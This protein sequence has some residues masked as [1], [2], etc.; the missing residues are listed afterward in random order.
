MQEIDKLYDDFSQMPQ[1]NWAKLAKQ[2]LYWHK[3]FTETLV[4]KSYPE[5]TWFADG[6]TNISYNCLDT[7]LK[8]HSNKTALH[9]INSQQK[10]TKLSYQELHTEVIKFANY[11]KKLGINKGDFITFYMPLSCEAVIAMLA[12]VRIGAIHSIVFAGFSAEALA[13][14]IN[15]TK[16][17]WLI[18][19]DIGYRKGKELPLLE[20]CLKAHES[21][22]IENIV[23]YNRSGKFTKPQN[24]EINFYEMQ[25]YKKESSDSDPISWQDAE[26]PSFVLYTSG[27][28]GKPKGLVHSTGGYLLWAKLSTRL[29]F[30]LKETDTYWCTAD[31]GWITGHTYLVYGPLANAATIFFYEDAPDFPNTNI[32]W[33]LIE[34]HKISIFYTAPTAIRSFMK[35]Q[36]DLAI[37]QDLSS[38]RIL[39][40]VGEPINPKAWH[41]FNEEIGKKS[42]PIVDTWWQTETGGIMITSLPGYHK[43]KAGKAGLPLPG[44]QA[45]TDKDNIL[46]IKEPFPSL[47]RTVNNDAQRYH[48]T[49]WNNSENSYLA[50]DSALVDEDGFFEIQGRIDDVI[51]VSGHRLGTAEIESSA[52]KAQGITEAAVVSK[53]D[54]IKG[55]A[56]VIFAVANNEAKETA[57]LDQI[58]TDIGSFAKPEEIIFCKALPKTRSGKIMRRLLK[59]IAKREFP[60]GD[61]STLEDSKVIEDLIKTVKFVAT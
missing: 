37:T 12:C 39:G 13:Q 58:K 11:L 41:W 46:Y 36:K 9:F 15:D 31:I 26:D 22:K 40:T 27:S 1:E 61:I 52:I 6:Q 34:K 7:H 5:F 3:D 30:D 18:T 51:N 2:E 10:E 53:P 25:D 49:Y 14:R 8:K 16:S 48:D 55:E 38:L 19:A 24:S 54:N 32:F 42:C 29:V 57:L 45:Y 33:E 43:T 20:T 59:Q 50:G 60:E 56:I 47:A 35:W 28:T 4:K 23:V 17:K 44:I 21:Q